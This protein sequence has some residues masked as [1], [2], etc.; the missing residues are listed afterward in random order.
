MYKYLN[1]NQSNE[2]I[3]KNLQEILLKNEKVIR[4]KLNGFYFD[5]DYFNEFLIYLIRAK[6]G[7]IV[8]INEKLENLFISFLDLYCNKFMGNLEKNSIDEHLIVKYFESRH[9]IIDNERIQLFKYLFSIARNKVIKQN[10]VIKGY[11]RHFMIET[12]K[13]FY[14]QHTNQKLEKRNDV[15]NGNIN[16]IYFIENENLNNMD[17][18]IKIK[19]KSI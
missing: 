8:N 9:I 7:N 10:I 13:N 5:F 12:F 17:K 15:I 14:Y 4:D 11:A 3:N 6:P 19:I 2:K 1:Q 18:I 16:I